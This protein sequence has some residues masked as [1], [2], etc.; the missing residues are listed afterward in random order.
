MTIDDHAKLKELEREIALR[1][2]VYPRLIAKGQL[3]EQ[4]A[5]RA[6]EIMRAIADDYRQKIQ[7]S[8]WD[9]KEDEPA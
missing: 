4:G 7:P 8:L 5:A 3:S 6:I 9:G 2:W 1:R